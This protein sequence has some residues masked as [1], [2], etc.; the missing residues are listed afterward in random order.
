M[1]I[2]EPLNA[3][4]FTYHVG[5][6]IASV[7]YW[8]AGG[9]ILYSYKLLRNEESG[10]P[11]VPVP[12]HDRQKKDDSHSNSNS[13]SQAD[14]IPFPTP[15]E[16]QDETIAA[17][18]AVCVVAIVLVGASCLTGIPFGAAFAF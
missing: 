3:G 6:D 1:R 7:K 8:Y 4:M 5:Q 13:N 15:N 2:G 10:K 9:V 12:Y 16:E 11:S 14:I 18:A 17:I